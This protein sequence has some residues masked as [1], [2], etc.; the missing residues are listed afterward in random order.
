MQLLYRAAMVVLTGLLLGFYLACTV[1]GVIALCFYDNLS[2]LGLMAVGVLL[3]QGG[4]LA[5][6]EIAA[7][8]V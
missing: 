8:R 6:S 3:F 7:L 5:L 1:Y 2:G 4:R